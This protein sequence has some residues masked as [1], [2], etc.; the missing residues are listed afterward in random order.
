MNSRLIESIQSHYALDE[1]KEL[2]PNFAAAD[3][4]V[5]LSL[6]ARYGRLDVLA[7]LLSSIPVLEAPSSYI[8]EYQPLAAKLLIAC[9]ANQVEVDPIITK[10]LYFRALYKNEMYLREVILT[11]H[12]K[13]NSLFRL[14]QQKLNKQ[15]ESAGAD[16]KESKRNFLSEEAK[17]FAAA[18]NASNYY[19]LTELCK[20]CSD[21]PAL[22]ADLLESELPELALFLFIGTGLDPFKIAKM[23]CNQPKLLNRFIPLVSTDTGFMLSLIDQCIIDDVEPAK[24]LCELAKKIKHRLPNFSLLFE[25][26]IKIRYPEVS[27]QLECLSS[28]SEKHYDLISRLGRRLDLNFPPRLKN[29]N[30][31]GF[32]SLPNDILEVMLSYIGNE[33]VKYSSQE[34]LEFIASLTDHLN[35]CVINVKYGKKNVNLIKRLKKEI[36]LLHAFQEAIAKQPG[37]GC[38]SPNLKLKFLQILV[39]IASLLACLGVVTVGQMKAIHYRDLMHDTLADSPWQEGKL[40]CWDR[41]GRGSSNFPFYSIAN[42]GGRCNPSQTFGRDEC[43]SLCNSLLYFSDIHDG[44]LL[45]LFAYLLCFLSG[46]LVDLDSRR[47]PISERRITELGQAAQESTTCLLNYFNA[48]QESPLRAI[49]LESKLADVKAIADTLQ[50]DATDRV[51]RLLNI[52][53][54]LV[55]EH[56]IAIASSFDEVEDLSLATT[57]SGF[58]SLSI[59]NND[60]RAQLLDDKKC[61]SNYG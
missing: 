35:V 13:A 16:E 3:Q 6:A 27:F 37:V 61:S 25:R 22:L 24:E 2:N 49:T 4:S 53:R 57:P 43:L 29:D 18:Y 55:P 46:A 21:H 32:G 36:D 59:N 9:D 47:K 7:W 52:Q 5:A 17:N 45:F 10:A 15:K 26:Q 39:L 30:Q 20:T 34:T 1:I 14:E 8:N 42:Q 38:L 54:S 58:F 50:T 40:S 28:L 11:N 60:A 23:W 19:A 51:E 56:K 44:G 31:V 41:Y 48:Q 33:K 12:A